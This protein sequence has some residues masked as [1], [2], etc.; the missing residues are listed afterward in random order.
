AAKMFGFGYSAPET[1]DAFMAAYTQALQAGVTLIEIN[2]P[3]Q[4]VADDLK[5]IGAA[6]RGEAREQ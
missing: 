5:D 2:V 3:H 6:I 4:Q 1:L